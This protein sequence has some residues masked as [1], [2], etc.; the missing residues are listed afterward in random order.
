MEQQNYFFG[1]DNNYFVA[2]KYLLFDQ[3]KNFL[4]EKENKHTQKK[5]VW[6][7]ERVNN[8]FSERN[9][10]RVKLEDKSVNAQTIDFVVT[11]F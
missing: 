1:A 3:G 8:Y 2:T 7:K 6:V 11:K 4:G 9:K 10:L 5:G